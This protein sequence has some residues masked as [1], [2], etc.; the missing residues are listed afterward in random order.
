VVR[1]TFLV[2]VAGALAP[3]SGHA[4]QPL[5]VPRL[6]VLL[7]GTPDTDP[8][9]AAFRQGLERFGY[10]ESR[11]IATH[12]RYAGG[13]VERLRDLAVELV[14]VKPDVIL[15]LG[16]DVAPFVR[17]ATASIPIVAVVS[18]DPLQSGLVSSMARP[19]GNV[20]GLTFVS[21]DLAAKRL[22]FLKEMA[23]R[24][25]RVGIL[26]KPDH[27]DPEYRDPAGL[28][29]ARRPVAVTGGPEQQ[30]LPRGLH[31]G[32]RWSRR[33][34]RGGVVTPDDRESPAHHPVFGGASTRP[35]R[36]PR[37]PGPR[38]GHSSA[39]VRSSTRSRRGLR[40]TSTRS[41]RARSRPTSRSSSPQSSNW[42]ST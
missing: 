34:P 29:G 42:S 8:N 5:R 32:D 18:N 25:S 23:P 35:G 26:W 27:V 33:G 22:Q 30:R 19:A 3:I 13:Q 24:V 11:N 4:Q 16:G 41:S 28:S 39:M 12:Y 14:A 15:A 1:R 20:T 37:G 2:V 31:G 38:R 17:A 36:R 40:S 6:G 7:F 21:S 10:V 9:L